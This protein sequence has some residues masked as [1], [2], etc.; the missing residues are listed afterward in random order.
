ML[1]SVTIIFD[2]LNCFY[3]YLEYQRFWLKFSHSW[4]IPPSSATFNWSLMISANG[5]PSCRMPTQL[6]VNVYVSFSKGDIIFNV[7]SHNYYFISQNC[8][9]DFIACNLYL[10]IQNFWCKLNCEVKSHNYLLKCF[11][12]RRKQASIDLPAGIFFFFLQDHL[13]SIDSFV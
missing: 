10:T 11:I 1:T 9:S 7:L 3:F 4:Q 2:S 12:L 5:C 6:E 8:N 13:K